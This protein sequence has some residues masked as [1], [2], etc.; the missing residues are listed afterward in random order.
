M[1]KVIYIPNGP[2]NLAGLF[3]D[4]KFRDIEQYTVQLREASGASLCEST[5]NVIVLCEDEVNVH[6]I[7]YLGSIDTIPFLLIVKESESKSS[8]FERSTSY[9]LVRSDHSFNR[10]NIKANDTFT[11]RTIE[12]SEN[13]MEWMKELFESPLAWMEWPG[14]Q[15]EPDDYL[16]IVVLDSKFQEVKEDE[17]YTYE[18]TLACK[19]S[20]ERILLRN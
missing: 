17:R 11:L 3:P 4:I 16:P 5:T 9:P 7:N 20:H 12:Y 8:E 2:K 18:V 13:E 1:S 10:F 15:G 14:Q 6:F 19:L